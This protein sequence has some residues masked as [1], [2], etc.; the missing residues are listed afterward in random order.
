MNPFKLFSINR[1]KTLSV[2]DTHENNNIR[3]FLTMDDDFCKLYIEQPFVNSYFLNAWV[4]IAINILIRNIARADY[5]IKIEGEDIRHGQVY[6]LFR[7]P[8]PA[9]SRYDLWKETAAWWYLEGEAFWWFGS[10]YSGG[11]PKEIYILDPR[12]MCYEAEQYGAFDFGFRHIPRRW[13]YHSG[14]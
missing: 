4:N 6:E 3:N 2:N 1:N 10:D 8:N 14:T 5:T 9:L 13:F 7:K 12:K 11:L